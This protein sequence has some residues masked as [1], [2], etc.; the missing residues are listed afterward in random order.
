M[1]YLLKTTTLEKNT[2]SIQKLH[3]VWSLSRSKDLQASDQ[4][5]FDDLI[6]S[7]ISTGPFYYYI[8]DFFDLS[9]S[10]ISPSIY[11]IHDFQTGSLSLDLILETI[12]PDDLE[13]VVQ[14]E[15]FITQFFYQKL[16]KDK[17]LNYKMSYSFRS[18]MKDGKYKLLNHQAIM[19]SMSGDGLTGKSLNIHTQIDHLSHQNTYKISLIGLNGEP[20]YMN[21]SLDDKNNSRIEL[22]K[23]EIDIIRLISDGNSNEQIAILLSISPHTVKKH[24]SN[25]LEKT[26]CNNTAQLIK[27]CIQQ[28]IF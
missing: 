17:L 9:L 14:A 13:F 24:R 2:T 21:L 19:L 26:E 28:G 3:D 22:S 6:N 5:G 18:K 12:H 27:N 4:I 23:R 11:D 1:L 10:S 16:G 25:I 15:A 20:S 7:I 8:I